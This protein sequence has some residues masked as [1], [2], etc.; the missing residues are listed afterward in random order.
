MNKII[1][2]YWEPGSC[3]D[4]IH[5]LML[6]NTAEYQGVVTDFTSTDQGRLVPTIGKFFKEN[7]DCNHQQWY[8]RSWSVVDCQHLANF[9]NTLENKNF[10]I[11]THRYDQLKFL[12]THFPDSISIGITYPK[13]MFPL[14][15]KNWCKKVAP[16]DNM[17]NKIYNQ[18]LHQ[19]LKSKNRFGEFILTE[20]LKFGSNIKS[21][22]SEHFDLEIALEDLYSKNLKSIHSLFINSTHVEESFNDWI[23]KQNNIHQYHYD[24]PQILQSALGYNSKCTTP[25]DLSIELDIFDYIAIKHQYNSFNCTKAMPKFK[26]L[27]QSMIFFKTFTI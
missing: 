5:S 6:S 24:M 15:L 26:T 13:N 19:L 9:V 16:N 21:S 23:E 7:F 4:F 27:Q 3:G 12:K 22:V 17:L 14:V 1:I 2:L 8:L 25:G 11:P 10:V 18:P 20:Q